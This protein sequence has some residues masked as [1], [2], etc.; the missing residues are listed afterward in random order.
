MHWT[1][2]E[3]RGLDLDEYTVIVE[4]MNTRQ[5]PTYDGN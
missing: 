1:L 4:E 5:G 3:V 2:D